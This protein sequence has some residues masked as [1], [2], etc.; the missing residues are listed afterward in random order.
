M[1]S[2][3]I[4]QK[5]CHLLGISVIPR[6]HRFQ[7]FSVSRRGYRSLDRRFATL[8]LPFLPLSACSIRDGLP[9]EH[10]LSTEEHQ[11]CK[12]YCCRDRFCGRHS[13]SMSSG[14]YF[15]SLVV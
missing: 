13:H 4:L 2:F 6:K 9:S 3:C 10:D 5:G 14:S 12:I 15:E 11:G 1:V 7:R 8:S